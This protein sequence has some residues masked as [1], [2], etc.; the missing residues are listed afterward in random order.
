MLNVSNCR[1]HLP[2]YSGIIYHFNSCAIAHSL[3]D[4]DR[5]YSWSQFDVLLWRV[6]RVCVCAQ[7]EPPQDNNINRKK[8]MAGTRYSAT[9]KINEK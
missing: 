1:C 5:V 7:V 6:M 3:A 4:G 2:V 8:K 9:K